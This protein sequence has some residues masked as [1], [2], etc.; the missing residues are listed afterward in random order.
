MATTTYSAKQVYISY[1][2]HTIHGLAED[3]F[4]TID[5][6]TEGITK[7]V[8][9]DGEVARA[10]IPDK[11]YKVRIVLLQTS[12]SNLYLQTQY[13]ADRESGDGIQALSIR[14]V[15]GNVL[16][17]ADAW[18]TRSASITYGREVASREWNFDTAEAADPF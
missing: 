3:S 9:C 17:Q 7:K 12:A 2:T 15:K 6:N 14:D 5:P 10:I 4:V 1:G 18:I 11:T 8:G 13:H 16:F